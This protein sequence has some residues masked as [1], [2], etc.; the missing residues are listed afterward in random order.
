M[1]DHKLIFCSRK[2]K[3]A[4]FEKHKDAFL[5]SNKHYTFNLFLEELQIKLIFKF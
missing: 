4:K 1:S 2:V 5:R 3:Q